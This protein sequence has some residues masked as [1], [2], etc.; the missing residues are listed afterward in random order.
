MKNKIRAK[1]F[2]THGHNSQFKDNTNLTNKINNWLDE[3]GEIELIDVK[4]SSAGGGTGN[5]RFSALIFY[6]TL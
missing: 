6:K 1:H 3:V 4:Y 5:I 2:D